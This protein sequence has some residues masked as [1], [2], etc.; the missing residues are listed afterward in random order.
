MDDLEKYGRYAK[1]ISIFKGLTPEEVSEILH[2]GRASLFRKGDTIF[3]KGQLGR[4][5]FVVMGGTVDIYDGNHMIARCRVGDA[6]GEMSVLDHRPHSATAV[7]AVDVKLFTLDEDEVNSMLE[8]HIAV[9]FLLNI[10]HVLSS[11]LA[12]S[13]KAVSLLEHKLHGLKNSA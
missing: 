2:R 12:D 1:R 7:A 8:Q 3:H 4:T 13:N 10:I 9:R 6:F 11:H 5:L